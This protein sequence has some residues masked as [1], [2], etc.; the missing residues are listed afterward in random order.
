MACI[1]LDRE[2]KVLGRMVHCPIEAQVQQVRM[3]IGGSRGWLGRRL[4]LWIEAGP[5][6][7][8]R[9]QKPRQT[10]EKRQGG[11]TRMR[12]GEQG[13]RKVEEGGGEV[14]RVRSR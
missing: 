1:K 6:G 12:R 7:Q 11:V 13:M 10:S 8:V 9:R 4:V 3:G 5:V 14:K 2:F